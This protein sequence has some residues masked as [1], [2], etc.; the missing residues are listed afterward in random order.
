[1]FAL[2][3]PFFIL[4]LLI[5]VPVCAG[6][7]DTD[8]DNPTNNGPESGLEPGLSNE[9]IAGE[10]SDLSYTEQ[11]NSNKRIKCL[12]G[13]AA[14]KTGDHATAIRIFEDCIRR[15]EDVYSMIWLAQIYE[16]GVGAK[17]DLQ[18]ATALM[19]RGAE[20][21]DAAGYSSLARYHYGVALYE[22]TGTQVD[23]PLALHYLRIACQEHVGEACKYLSDNKKPD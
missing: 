2:R 7:L 17:Q 21:Q 1:M 6:A 3:T 11:V 23:K 15:W 10:Y 14:D 20:T 4:L 9:T 16:S 18:K 5:T 12:Y 19:K 8:N 22:G 13:Y